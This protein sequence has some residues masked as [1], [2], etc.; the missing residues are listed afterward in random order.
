MAQGTSKVM[1]NLMYVL[2]FVAVLPSIAVAVLSVSAN[3]SGAALV[4]VGL[5][6]LFMVWGAIQYIRKQTGT[7]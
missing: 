7:R 5:I 2:I 4:L 6:P 3:L 1:D